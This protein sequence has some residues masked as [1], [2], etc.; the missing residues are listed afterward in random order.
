MRVVLVSDAHLGG[1]SD[2][3]QRR[4]LAW[5]GRLPSVDRLCILGDL[6]QHWWDFEGEPFAEY[7]PVVQALSDFPL[8]FVPGNHDWRAG[9]WLRD[10]QGADTGSSLRYTWDGLRVHLAHGD[11]ADTS[12]GYAWMS[13]LLR[14]RAFATLMSR[15]GPERGWRLLG[16][17]AGKPHEDRQADPTL[18]AAQ[19]RIAEGL[20]AEVDLVAFGHTHAP[21]L[22]RLSRGWYANL[23][24]RVHHHSSLWIVEGQPELRRDA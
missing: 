21:E 22:S 18:L 3:G 15:L 13:G 7:R 17:I 23:G 20:L 24:D 5:L 19:R 10:F 12:R 11:E 9:Q 14:G 2:P 16:K 8:S 4:F 6:F 1:P